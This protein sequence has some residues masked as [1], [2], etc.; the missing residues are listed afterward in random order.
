MQLSF[1]NANCILLFENGIYKLYLLHN[2][3]LVAHTL[4]ESRTKSMA[5]V[6]FV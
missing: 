1:G 5:S 2:N 6:P 3:T 4:L